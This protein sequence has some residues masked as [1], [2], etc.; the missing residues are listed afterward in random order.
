MQKRKQS[1][2]GWGS[3]SILFLLVALISLPPQAIGGGNNPSTPDRGVPAEQMTSLSGSIQIIHGDPPVGSGIEPRTEVVLIGDSGEWTPIQ[4]DEALARSSGSLMSLKGK[5]VTVV[6]AMKKI[7]P[8]AAS[9]KRHFVVHEI[10][11]AQRQSLGSEPSATESL[12]ALVTTGSKPWVT[13]L[14]RFAGSTGAPPQTNEWF[15]TLMG[16]NAPGMDHYWREVSYNNINL[17]GSKVV[18]WYNLPHPRLAY[19]DRNGDGIADDLDWGRAAEDC[20]T[21]ADADVFFPDFMGINLMFDQ[22][23]DCCSWGVSGSPSNRDGITRAYAVTWMPPWGYQHHAT[24]AHE[25][26]HGFGLP[27]SFSQW[28]PMGVWRCRFPDPMLSCL[29][30]HLIS[31]QKDKLGWIPAAR[32]YEAAPGSLQTI[33]IERLA[34]P[35]SSSNYLIAQI[36]IGGSATTFYTVEARR[37]IGNYDTQVPFEA[38][39]IHRVDTTASDPARVMDGTFDDT[40]DTKWIPGETFCDPVNKV[41][42]AVNSTTA[43]GFNVTIERDG[44]FPDTDGDGQANCVEAAAGSDPLNRLSIPEVCDGLNNDLDG[45]V[46]EGFTNT[47]GDGQAN[48][49]DADDDNDGFSDTAE[50]AAGTDSLNRLSSP[51]VCDGLDNDLDGAVDEGFT[52]TDGDGQANCVDADDD[53]DGFSDATETAAGSDPLNRLS[54]PEACDGVDNDLNQ[55]ID[56]DFPNTDGDGQANCVDADDDNDGFSDAT[57]AAAATDPLNGASYPTCHG[58]RA[59]IVGTPSP[60]TITGTSGPDVIAGLAGDDLIRGG[61]GNDTICGSDGNDTLNGGFG[62]DFL[63][64]GSGNDS[65]YGRENNDI[66]H[67]SAGNDSLFGGIGTDECRGDS[68]AGDTAD[69]VNCEIISGVP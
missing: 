30:G 47:D 8:H 37:F 57:E 61:D 28:E 40:F 33:D 1:T 34:Q 24:L 67:G 4:I 31:Y 38:I 23:L 10:R 42:V 55:G 54:I 56:E 51:E 17:A 68:G 62:N 20:A 49:V 59:T 22:T 3:S 15:E 52:N 2:L 60:E 21:A 19:M 65:L 46:D 44:S 43:A 35:V 27:H 13:I 11:S 29:G 45:T 12:N 6:G 26:G 66:L 63:N 69:R 32:R 41:R 7:P 14:C 53:N 58:L 36:P 25:M 48:C 16:A 5:R 50:A 9:H 39:A 64:G 18:G